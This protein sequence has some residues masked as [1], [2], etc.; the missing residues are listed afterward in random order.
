MVISTS[1]IFGNLL[2]RRM[3]LVQFYSKCT[4]KSLD[5]HIILRLYDSFLY[6]YLTHGAPLPV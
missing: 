6:S 1:G 3:C 4:Y 2:P 5:V